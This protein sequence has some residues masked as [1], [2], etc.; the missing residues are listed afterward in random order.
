MTTFDL[1]TH[2]HRRLNI[3]TGEWILVSP[4]RTERPW[5]GKV[6]QQGDDHRE[7]YDPSC[8]LCPGNE[9]ANG[10]KNPAYASTFVFTNDF[11]ALIPNVPEGKQSLQDLLVAKSEPGICR[12]VCFSPR[13]DLTLAEM[14]LADIRTV[15]DVWAREYD[16]LGARPEIN[17]IQIFE[18]KGELMGCSNP[19]PHGQI[20]AQ[21]SIPTDPAKEIARMEEHQRIHGSCLLCEY[22]ALEMKEEERIVLQN[23]DLGVIVPFWA[24]W[25]FETIILPRRHV[26][27]I[28]QFTDPERDSF[29]EVIKRLT[30][31]YDNLFKTSFPYSAGLHQSPTDGR[32][33]LEYH[34]HMH[35]YPPLLRSASVKK[36][37]VGYEML[38]NPQRD[39]TPES[40]SER[41]RQLPDIHYSSTVNP[42]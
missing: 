6:E 10:E 7:S 11:S 9:R 26:A 38:A 29:A 21:R 25:P 12:V 2:P 32:T 20:W 40:S 24:V 30:T 23:D 34:T 14:E 5:R 42:P 15:V 4:H 16:E 37:M 39:I 8:Y 41:L 28:G 18:N 19:H 31:R 17:H 35:F 36:F 27:S 33:H 13:H 1:S 3:L 22:L